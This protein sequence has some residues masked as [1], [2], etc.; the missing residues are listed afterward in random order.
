MLGISNVHI[1]NTIIYYIPITHICIASFADPFVYH[2]PLASA[3]LF[4]FEED[5]DRLIALFFPLLLIKLSFGRSGPAEHRPDPR[6]Q[7]RPS[8]AKRR[9]QVGAGKIE[10]GHALYIGLQSQQGAWLRPNTGSALH[11]AS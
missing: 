2:Y 6:Q 10:D 7:G 4:A 5:I 11:Q 9:P 8:R 1:C 3:E